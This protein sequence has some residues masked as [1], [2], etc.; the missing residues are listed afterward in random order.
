MVSDGR[1]EL[2]VAVRCERGRSGVAQVPFHD[3]DVVVVVPYGHPWERRPVSVSEMARTPFVRRDPGANTRVT[4]DRE[5]ARLGL[6]VVE[7]LMEVGSTATAKAVAIQMGAPA[8]MSRTALEPGAGLSDVQITGASFKREFV[9]LRA[10]SEDAMRAPARHL[11]AF[12]EQRAA[13]Q[14]D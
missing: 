8:V 4:I 9:L 7:P 3:D 10:A 5:L 11:A 6:K 1:A 13:A 12:L 14:P 2:G